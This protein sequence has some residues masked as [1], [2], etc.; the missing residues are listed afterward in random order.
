MIISKRLRFE[1]DKEKEKTNV[2]KH[3]VSFIDAAQV[4]YDENALV[5]Y[6]ED[7]SYNEERYVILGMCPNGETYTVVYCL[8]EQETVIRIISARK[9]VKNEVITYFMK[10]G[11]R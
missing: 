2:K 7:H 3:G 9:A 8:K 11:E 6:D 4:F 10:M 5:I 1:W